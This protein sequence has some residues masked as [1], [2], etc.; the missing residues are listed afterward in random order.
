MRLPAAFSHYRAYAALQKLPR[1]L[2]AEGVVVRWFRDGELG[3]PEFEGGLG[4]VAGH[5]SIFGW[6]AGS[7]C[8]LR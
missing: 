8:A 2:G 7:A 6:G 5:T 1:V 4:G 3:F